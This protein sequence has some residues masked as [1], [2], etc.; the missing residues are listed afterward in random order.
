MVAKMHPELDTQRAS[1]D[2]EMEA[3]F[4]PS[5]FSCN[6][7]VWILC[8][9]QLRRDYILPPPIRHMSSA[10][11]RKRSAAELLTQFSQ[12]A[13]VLAEI[14]TEHLPNTSVERYRIN[15]LLGVPFYQ[16]G[17]HSTSAG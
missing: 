13:D 1:S 9:T 4:V 2:R 8:R 11:F 7:E 17:S 16:N 14:R 5:A 3:M 6:L 10:L 12:I 15:N